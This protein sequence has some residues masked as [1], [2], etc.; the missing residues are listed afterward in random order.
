[1][2]EWEIL[3]EVS[4]NPFPTEFVIGAVFFCGFYLV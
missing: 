2:V 4:E 3:Y 1:M